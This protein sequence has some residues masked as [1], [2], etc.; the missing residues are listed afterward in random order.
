MYLPEPVSDLRTSA[1]AAVLSG[2][3]RDDGILELPLTPREGYGPFEF[4]FALASLN[5]DD[6]TGRYGISYFPTT[7]LIGPDGV[8]I[9]KDIRGQAIVDK[10]LSLLG[11]NAG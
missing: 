10:V 11:K 2:C 8:I 4:G 3:S 6:I 7:Y 9:E 1:A 5:T